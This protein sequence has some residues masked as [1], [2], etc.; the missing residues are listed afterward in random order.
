MTQRTWFDNEAMKQAQID[1]DNDVPGSAYRMTLIEAK[2]RKPTIIPPGV[3]PLLG[4]GFVRTNKTIIV[5]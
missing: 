3:H 5:S 4:G 2:R 1:I